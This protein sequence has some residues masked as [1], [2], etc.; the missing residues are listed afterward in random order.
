MVKDSWIEQLNEKYKGISIEN[1]D[2]ANEIIL[3]CIDKLN[4][5]ARDV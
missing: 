1:R 4:R 3:E 2:K 5:L